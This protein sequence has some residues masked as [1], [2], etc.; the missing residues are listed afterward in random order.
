MAPPSSATPRFLPPVVQENGRWTA[1]LDQHPG[2][3]DDL[4]TFVAGLIPVKTK[5]YRYLC[6]VVLYIC[7]LY[8]ANGLR[9]INMTGVFQAVANMHGCT[10]S[11]LSSGITGELRC[12][13]EF[14]NPF[15]C[16]FASGGWLKKIY[17]VIGTLVMRVLGGEP[18]FTLCNDRQLLFVCREGRVIDPIEYRSLFKHP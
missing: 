12:A 16:A 3:E 8:I 2:V 1:F 4:R 11:S 9:S 6:D 18:S 10:K 14:K 5:S 7:R 15:V 17:P 13:V